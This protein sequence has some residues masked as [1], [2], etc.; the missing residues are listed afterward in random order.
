M[1]GVGEMV[2][3]IKN[4]AMLRAFVNIMPDDHEALSEFE[5]L[6]EPIFHGV[7]QS[8]SFI[9]AANFRQAWTAKAQHERV[10]VNDNLGRIFEQER[11]WPDAPQ[12]NL[13]RAL[14]GT[15]SRTAIEVN[16]GDKEF[17]ITIR[18]RDL[19]DRLVLILLTSEHLGICANP[20]CAQK[21]FVG[22]DRKQKYC[23]Y[24]C[25]DVRRRQAKLQWW[26]DKG[27]QW[28]KSKPKKT[29]RTKKGRKAR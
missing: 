12:G 22:T 8:E 27:N 16:Y 5:R 21:Y 23:S 29:T 6:Y 24:E 18:P 4:R 2:D 3:Q 15:P 13:Q 9:H 7:T 1:I 17:P 14:G 11:A 20:E 10:Q 25:A 26:Q 28:R 19:L